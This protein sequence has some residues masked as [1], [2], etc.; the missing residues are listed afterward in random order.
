MDVQHV[1]RGEQAILLGCKVVEETRWRLAKE[2]AYF[3]ST[4]SGKF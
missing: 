3:R 1:G 4:R 2:S